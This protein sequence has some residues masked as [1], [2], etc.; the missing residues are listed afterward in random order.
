VEARARRRRRRVGGRRIEAG[1]KP[2][3]IELRPATLEDE[4][5]TDPATGLERLVMR[6]TLRRA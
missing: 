2:P 1:V 6:K 5:L 4:P 3:P